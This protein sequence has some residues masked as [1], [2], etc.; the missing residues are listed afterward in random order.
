MADFAEW[1]EAVSRGLGWGTNTFVSTYDDNRKQAGE[2]M[3]EGSALAEVLLQLSLSGPGLTMPATE[4]YE[5]LV[6]V[7]G[8]RIAASA[9]WPKTIALFA[10]ELRHLAPQLLLQG[11]SITFER[12][13][14]GRFVRLEK[15]LDQ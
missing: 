6:R 4:L 9:A 8:K 2:V 13:K 1:G 15:L 5:H 10:Q 3:L 12:R 14:D 11:L 7:A